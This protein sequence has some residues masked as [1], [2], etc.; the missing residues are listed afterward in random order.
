MQHNQEVKLNF[1]T[2]VMFVAELRE[3]V[4]HIS[5]QGYSSLI[6]THLHSTALIL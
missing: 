3:L 4:I 1:Y 5:F 2:D 6:S